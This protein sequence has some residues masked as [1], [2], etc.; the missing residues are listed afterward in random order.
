MGEATTV[1][2]AA[3]VQRKLEGHRTVVE[4]E[5]DRSLSTAVEDEEEGFCHDG[6][7]SE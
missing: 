6:Y 2:V 7:F 3:A 1:E 5:K 4:E